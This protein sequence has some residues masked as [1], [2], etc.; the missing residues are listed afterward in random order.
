MVSEP[1]P[2]HLPQLSAQAECCWSA[3]RGQGES[4]SWGLPPWQLSGPEE[5]GESWDTAHSPQSCLQAA[6]QSTHLG[7]GRLRRQSHS[8]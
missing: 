4:S 3:E 8:C 7:F 6:I 2:K 1:F 5:L